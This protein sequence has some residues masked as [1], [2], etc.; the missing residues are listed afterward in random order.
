MSESKYVRF[1][2]HPLWQKKRLEI[3][4]LDEFKC[5]FCCSEENELQVHHRYYVPGRMPWEYP[6]FALIT[7]CR[8][9]HENEKESPCD[10][11]EES[12]EMFFNEWAMHGAR[13]YR[14]RDEKMNE[15]A[16]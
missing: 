12:A 5:R 15:T 8:K 6:Y 16:K 7:L 1:Y 14:W 3:L 4:E 11:W 13:Y 2:R 9:C 10:S